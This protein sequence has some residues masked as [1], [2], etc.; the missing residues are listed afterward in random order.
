MQ[1][2]RNTVGKESKIV[3]L[4]IPEVSQED[5]LSADR[6]VANRQPVAVRR[7]RPTPQTKASNSLIAQLVLFGSLGILAAIALNS[8]D[9]SKSSNQSNSLT[10][11][12]QNSSSTEDREPPDAAAT[13]RQ[14]LAEKPQLD[15][16]DPAISGHFRSLIATQSATPDAVG[17]RR[18]TGDQ[19]PA[20]SIINPHRTAPSTTVPN[21][22][23]PHASPANEA[24]THSPIVTAQKL[25]ETETQNR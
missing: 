4:P 5:P 14:M 6:T 2:T 3:V 1:F 8:F 7:S 24:P 20:P 10:G 21:G 11:A 17:Q 18:G 15:I 19:S 23:S 16:R 13:S 12:D 25:E 9:N 22:Q